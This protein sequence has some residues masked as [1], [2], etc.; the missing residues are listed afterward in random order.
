MAA[1]ALREWLPNVLQVV[2]PWMSAED[3]DKGVRWSSDI[4]EELTKST[5]GIICITAENL[6]A[7][8]LHFEAGALSKDI[9]KRSL[10]CPYLIGLKPNEL[11]GPLIQFQAT[12]A[13]RKDTLKLLGTLNSALAQEALSDKQLEKVFEVWWPRFE[14][15]L[16]VI[17]STKVVPIPGPFE[18]VKLM[19]F[20]DYFVELLR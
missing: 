3:I 15:A 20:T 7:P 14:S 2:D 10:V 5:A 4:T 16:Q 8:W 12:V 6:E 11:R 9:E 13:E 19:A 18:V 17:L 1:E